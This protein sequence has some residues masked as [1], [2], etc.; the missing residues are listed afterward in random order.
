MGP[1]LLL[2]L[3]LSSLDVAVYTILAIVMDITVV[4]AMATMA[5]MVSGLLMLMLPLLLRPPLS[6]RL[7][8]SSLDV[9]MYVIMDMDMDITMAMAMDTMDKSIANFQKLKPCSGLRV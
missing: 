2:I 9:A 6:L 8:H 7:I 1:Q 3:I 4:M 5:T